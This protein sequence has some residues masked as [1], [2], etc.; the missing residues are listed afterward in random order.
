MELHKALVLNI[1]NYVHQ[2]P[3]NSSYATYFTSLP[4]LHRLPTMHLSCIGSKNCQPCPRTFRVT[5][6]TPATLPCAR[7]HPPKPMHLRSQYVEEETAIRASMTNSNQVKDYPKIQA[8]QG[9]CFPLATAGGWPF[10]RGEGPLS[11]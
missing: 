7:P 5:P 10:F 1:A 3:C 8:P 6:L 11:A 4:S 2:L 9:S